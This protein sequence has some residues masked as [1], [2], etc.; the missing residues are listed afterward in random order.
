MI[1]SKINNLNRQ[2]IRNNVVI[3]LLIAKN[4]PVAL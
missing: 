1:N 3:R 4:D 2:N